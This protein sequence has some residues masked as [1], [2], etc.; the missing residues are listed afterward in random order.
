MDC[1]G[2]AEFGFAISGGL[3]PPASLIV[4]GTCVETPPPC[5][6]ALLAFSTTRRVYDVIS[7]GKGNTSMDEDTYSR[8]PKWPTTMSIKDTSAATEGL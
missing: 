3:S 6:D 2:G 1:R 7:L 5:D 4:S 8:Y